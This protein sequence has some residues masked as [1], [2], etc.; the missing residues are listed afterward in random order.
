MKVIQMGNA[1]GRSTMI[2]VLNPY[3][4]RKTDFIRTTT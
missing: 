3:S 2:A 1:L 4:I